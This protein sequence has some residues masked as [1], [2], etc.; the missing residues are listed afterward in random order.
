MN[1][2][3]NSI[4]GEIPVS[5]TA[6][7]SLT[8][9]VSL[10]ENVSSFQP[11]FFNWYRGG[12]NNLLRVYKHYTDFP[13]TLNFSRNK[14]S[15]SICKEFGKMKHLHVLDLSKN[16]LSGSIPEEV[17]SMFNL[18]RLDLSFND[19]SGSTPSSITKLNF[20]SFFS[21]A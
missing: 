3:N 21:V 5:L 19:L 11:P 6:L 12:Q 17:S 8:L 15:G 10:H 9:G 13:P 14:M 18:D 20:L 7:R 2:S 4:W 1:L 16:N